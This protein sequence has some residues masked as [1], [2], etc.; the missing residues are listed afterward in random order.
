MV[1]KLDGSCSHAKTTKHRGSRISS[2]SCIFYTPNDFSFLF[3]Y[4]GWNSHTSSQKNSLEEPRKRGREEKGVRERT[5]HGW[6]SLLCMSDKLLLKSW[7]Q[8]KVFRLELL[9]NIVSAR[10]LPILNPDYITQGSV[11]SGIS[12]SLSVR[13]SRGS[14]YLSCF[15]QGNI[16]IICQKIILRIQ[17]E[18]ARIT[19]ISAEN[20]RGM[21]T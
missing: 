10:S 3:A 20:F 9:V 1:G 7:Q 2:G 18:N 15:F 8:E 13:G 14:N 19:S 6:L 12:I 16:E 21:S 11:H 5:W 17:S 4:N